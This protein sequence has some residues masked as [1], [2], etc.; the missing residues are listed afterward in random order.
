VLLN[1]VEIVEQPFAGRADVRTAQRCLGET[2][3]NAIEGLPR[4]AQAREQARA[5]LAQG[6]LPARRSLCARER[7]CAFREMLG[8]E[9]LS[10]DRAGDQAIRG[11]RAGRKPARPTG[12]R[13]RQCSYK[14]MGMCRDCRQRAS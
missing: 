1:D 5:P 10:T 6:R 7:S 12:E 8:A 13:D 14:A 9:Q 3:V 11:Q 4:V 2:G